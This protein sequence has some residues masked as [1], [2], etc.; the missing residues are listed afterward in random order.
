MPLQRRASPCASP[1]TACPSTVMV[2]LSGED[3][4]QLS[5][6]ATVKDVAVVSQDTG[7]GQRTLRVE[8]LLGDCLADRQERVTALQ[9]AYTVD[10]GY[11]GSPA[12][13]CAAAL[14]IA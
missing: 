6:Q 5:A 9:D 8:V 3:G 4:E 13:P 1:G 14:G 12:R 2:E 11:R 7:E 10:G